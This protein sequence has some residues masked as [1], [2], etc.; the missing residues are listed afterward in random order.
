M[1]NIG[2]NIQLKK[3]TFFEKVLRQ[4]NFTVNLFRKI[5]R[6]LNFP[7]SR[8]QKISRELN[9]ADLGKNREIGET[10]FPRKFL[11]LWYYELE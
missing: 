8:F 11:P 6:Q 3:K 9:F 2:K 4:S 1:K 5:L 10:F 7:D